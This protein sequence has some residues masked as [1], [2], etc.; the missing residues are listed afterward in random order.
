V[1]RAKNEDD[2]YE[3]KPV[4]LTRENVPTSIAEEPLF[5]K[6]EV[7]TANVKKKTYQEMLDSIA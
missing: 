7:K 2:D 6:T 4:K 3:G 1:V 5:L